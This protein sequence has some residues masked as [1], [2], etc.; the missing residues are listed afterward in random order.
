MPGTTEIPG[1]T[2]VWTI[3]PDGTGYFNIENGPIEEVDVMPVALLPTRLL[4]YRDGFF[5]VASLPAIPGCVW[6]PVVGLPTDELVQ[7][8]RL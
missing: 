4:L 7:V 2:P 5:D 6:I 1:E 8:V 3:E